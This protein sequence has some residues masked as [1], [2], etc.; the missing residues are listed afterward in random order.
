MTTADEKAPVGRGRRIF[1]KIL[2]I[3]SL[4]AVLAASWLYYPH[5]FDGPPLC[6]FKLGFGVPCMGCGLTRAFSAMAHGELATALTYNFMAPALL[7]YFA[8]WWILAVGRLLRPV[9]DPKW[10]GAAGRWIVIAFLVM[11]TG[12]MVVF[13]SHPA[14]AK[15]MLTQNMLMRIVTWNWD[16]TYEPYG[17]PPS[18]APPGA[19]HRPES[20]VSP[21]RPPG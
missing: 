19:V 2:V 6:W 15:S 13:F 9:A 1:R 17:S 5:A 10:L 7:A 4:P 11:Y 12:R 3:G 21:P 14:G 18:A 16:N 8:V 20:S